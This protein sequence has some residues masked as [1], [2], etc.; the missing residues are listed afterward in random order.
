M[1]QTLQTIAGEFSIIRLAPD[2]PLPS[3]A[4]STVFSTVSRTNEELSILCPSLNVP[5]DLDAKK[6]EGWRGLKLKGPF[7]F[8]EMGILASVLNPLAA[9]GVPILAISTFDTDYV[10][11]K[12]EN[13][14]KAAQTLTTAG[15]TVL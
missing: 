6:E 3:W 12:Q 5:G 7:E 1:P 15:H 14:E 4:D 10:F 2:A 13:L 9:A 8:T 11:V